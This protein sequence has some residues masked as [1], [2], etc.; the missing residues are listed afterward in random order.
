MGHLNFGGDGWNFWK[1]KMVIPVTLPETNMAPE[2]EA[3]PIGKSSSNPQ[4]SGA[5][6][7][8]RE[9]THWKINMEPQNCW[10]HIL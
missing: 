7:S 8:F 3:F 9:G 1:Q 2:K 5:M 6:F 10:L 4:Y